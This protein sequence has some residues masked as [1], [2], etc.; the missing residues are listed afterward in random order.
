MSANSLVTATALVSFRL[1][2]CELQVL[3]S[4]CCVI[5]RRQ[6]NVLPP[7]RGSGLFLSRMCAAGLAGNQTKILF[8]GIFLKLLQMFAG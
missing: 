2:S 6:K 4:Q 8:S 5:V 7:S 3:G 1:L